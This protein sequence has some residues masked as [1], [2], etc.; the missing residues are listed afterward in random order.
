MRTTFIRMMTVSLVAT[1]GLVSASCGSGG[2][3]GL[4]L[5]NCSDFPSV[6]QFG[7]AAADFNGDGRADLAIPINHIANNASSMNVYLQMPSGSNTLAP[8]VGYSLAQDGST[9]LAI[10]IDGD[11]RPDILTVGLDNNTITVLLNQPD[12]PGTF[13]ALPSF[14]GGK[15]LNDVTLADINGDGRLD[16]IESNGEGQDPSLDGLSVQLQLTQSP[17]EFAPPTFIPINGCCESVAVADVNGDGLPDLIAV[18]TGSGLVVL[19][20][21]PGQP[22]E[23]ESP[24]T[25]ISG[26]ATLCVKAVD[27]DGDGLVDLVYGGPTSPSGNARSVLVALQDANNP[28]HFLTPTAYPVADDIYSCVV[29]DLTIEHRPDIVLNTEK[30]ASVLRQDPMHPGTFLAAISYSLGQGV[31]TA[32]ADM[33]GDGLPDLVTSQG[34]SGAGPGVIYQDAAHPGTFGTFQDLH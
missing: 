31:Y 4:G 27:L 28:G 33:N 17:G 30:G 21:I 34:P 15:G 25:L 14:S 2:G 9:T 12:H 11:G 19:L 13:S 5:N 16:L 18:G 26:P 8:P 22:G 20:Q 29:Q 10:D 32:I 1:L 24:T 7:I 3:C 6:L 23:F